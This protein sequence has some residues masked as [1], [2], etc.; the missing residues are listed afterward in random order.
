MSF[1]SMQLFFPAASVLPRPAEAEI[2]WPD[3]KRVL[4]SSDSAL[5]RQGFDRQGPAS[6]PNTATA[7][8]GIVKE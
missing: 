2:L 4:H 8:H 5:G 6:D 3:C 7:W 1:H